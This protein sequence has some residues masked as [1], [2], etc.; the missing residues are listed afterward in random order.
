MVRSIIFPVIFVIV[1]FG[2]F[3]LSPNALA[4]DACD[5]DPI[6]EAAPV[7]AHEEMTFIPPR[8]TPLTPMALT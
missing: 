6:G 4:Y 1:I 8:F 2:I 3:G 7:C 5:V